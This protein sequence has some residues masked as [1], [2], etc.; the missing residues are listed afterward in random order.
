MAKVPVHA[1]IG[2][3]RTGKSALIARLCGARSD[4]LGFVNTAI[5]GSGTPNLRPVPG[6]CPCC[7][8]RVVLQVALTRALR[9]TGAVRVFVELA[10]ASHK[11]MFERVLGESPFSRSVVAGCSYALPDCE[12]LEAG[13]LDTG[14]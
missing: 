5:S 6:G 3:P 10:D 2:G 4:W 12:S 11:A 1:V 14:L 13:S 8:A 9:D 7:T